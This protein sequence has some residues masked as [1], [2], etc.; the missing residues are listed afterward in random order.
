[1]GFSL[2]YDPPA[3]FPSIRPP[4]V[5]GVAGPKNYQENPIIR[6]LE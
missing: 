6:E 1:M 3:T 2:T 4:G 5:G